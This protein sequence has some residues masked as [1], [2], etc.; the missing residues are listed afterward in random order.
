MIKGTFQATSPC[1]VRPIL[2]RAPPHS[3]LNSLLSFTQATACRSRGCNRAEFGVGRNAAAATGTAP[4]PP[5]MTALRTALLIAGAIAVGAGK[6]PNLVFILTGKLADA[7]CR[8]QECACQPATRSFSA[9]Q[10]I[11][12]GRGHGLPCTPCDGLPCSILPQMT[13]I[14]CSGPCSTCPRQR[15]S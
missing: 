5:G 12:A 2:A 13:R 3:L 4:S 10:A 7:A 15:L 9:P 8:K 11:T 6:P 1:I 14:C